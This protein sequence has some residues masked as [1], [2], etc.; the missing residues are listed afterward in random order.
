MDRDCAGSGGAL[1]HRTARVSG[2]S[3]VR[4]I[5]AIG[6]AAGLRWQ[7]PWPFTDHGNSREAGF[8]TW[9]VRP[10][11]A[12]RRSI[13][14]LLLND[15]KEW[16]HFTI[17][18]LALKT[19]QVNFVPGTEEY[20]GLDCPGGF[21]RSQW[22]TCL[23]LFAA[24][25]VAR[26][27]V[28]LPSAI[29]ESGHYRPNPPAVVCHS[30][31]AMRKVMDSGYSAPNPVL[32]NALV[33]QGDCML[34]PYRAIKTLGFPTDHGNGPARVTIQMSHGGVMTLW[35]YPVGD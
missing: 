6:S 17:P 3:Y 8:L 30:K 5:T 35:G 9:A 27:Q 34:V 24:V 10:L 23:W 1:I 14:P 29:N 2:L 33:K 11:M 19:F 4:Y 18:R 28:S 12:A 20:C 32:V 7:D 22:V 26:A 13:A 16:G 15:S 21:M 31:A 25:N